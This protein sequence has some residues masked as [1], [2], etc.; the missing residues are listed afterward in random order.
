M[1]MRR[2]GGTCLTSTHSVQSAPV[3]VSVRIEVF[4]GNL[5]PTLAATPLR[6]D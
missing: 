5:R 4:E 2:G 6:E 3:L 1:F